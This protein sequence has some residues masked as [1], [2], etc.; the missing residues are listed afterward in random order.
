MSTTLKLVNLLEEAVKPFDD[1]LKTYQE[2]L[3]T[4]TVD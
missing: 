1:P 4:L 3:K 2:F